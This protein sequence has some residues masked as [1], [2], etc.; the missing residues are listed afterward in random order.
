[1]S[2][3]RD[4]RTETAVRPRKL[5]TLAIACPAVVGL[6]LILLLRRDLIVETG[7]PVWFA[8]AAGLSALT[9]WAVFNLIKPT[10]LIRI[11]PAGLMLP[12][13]LN[14]DLGWAEI[15]KIE[16]ITARGR[17]GEVRDRLIIHLRQRTM[18]DWR[19]AGR[20]RLFAGLPQAA[21]AVDID[22]RWPFRAA[23]L[24]ALIEER[25]RDFASSPAALSETVT[26]RP[27]SAAPWRAVS[28]GFAALLPLAAHFADV[29]LPR[30][31]SEGMRLYQSG[32]I[33]AAVPF[34]ES[35]AR[36]GDPAAAHVLGT[37]YMNG[38]GVTRNPSMAAAWFLRAAE[39]GHAD[40]AY[41]LGDAHR[42]G[43][44]VAQEPG[45]ALAWF[46]KAAD[47]GSAAAAYTMAHMY[48]LGDGV[49]RDYGQAVK[50][51]NVAAKD[52]F[53]PAEH[54]LGKLYHEGVAVPRDPEIAKTWYL[55]AAE[56]G[57]IAARFDLARL[58]LDG[59]TTDR[60]AGLRYLA[61]SAESGYAPA[62]RR[63]AAVI[64]HGAGLPADPITAYK[65]ISLAE[66]AWPAGTRADLVR[67]K[68]RIAAVLS[69]A[70]IEAGKAQ[71]RAWRPLPR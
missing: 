14:Q 69:G 42:L 36:A 70:Q 12:R 68:A 67:E 41:R 55:R 38:D 1:M 48:R 22:I 71:I 62:Q 25:A 60:E 45:T 37:L 11:T 44:G 56:R 15:K 5:P 29:G 35:D 33:S 16:A 7:A 64:F 59:G 8:A 57:N 9:A 66:R 46:V 47:E 65:W 23:K 40:A 17:L 18:I 10:P 54:D 2:L 63:L 27:G 19:H 34:L 52:G 28:V 24:K 49:R 20:R 51:L 31:F 32:E 26:P 3:E 61:Q 21:I 39:A 30:L 13:L 50:W 4:I 43:V 6:A 58:L 53:A